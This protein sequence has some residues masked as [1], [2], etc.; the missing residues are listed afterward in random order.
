M[1]QLTFSFLT[2]IFGL[3]M[4]VTAD[5]CCDSETTTIQYGNKF[6][7]TFHL[8]NTGCNLLIELE[9]GASIKESF[10]TITCKD[11]DTVIINGRQLTK[12]FIVKDEDFAAVPL[13]TNVVYE[14]M[15]IVK[16][17][18]DDSSETIKS[19]N[20]VDTPEILFHP[21]L[22]DEADHI[23]FD[24]IEISYDSDNR[25]FRIKRNGEAKVK[26]LGEPRAEALKD[27][28]QDNLTWRMPSVS[29]VVLMTVIVIQLMVIIMTV[30]LLR[31]RTNV[32]KA[33]V[34]RESLL[35][36]ETSAS[37]ASHFSQ[38][39]TDSDG[40]CSA[41]SVELLEM[42]KN[43]CEKSDDSGAISISIGDDDET[44]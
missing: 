26:T 16:I 9:D 17:D 1:F 27:G 18:V 19:L 38:Y 32:A 24:D 6:G 14:H 4:S 23:T 33:V 20:L 34:R 21:S 8:D 11:Y 5:T 36:T 2:L 10:D 43:D 22:L 13:N 37:L 44:Q 40:D 12:P 25:Q 42:Q 3:V 31:S 35:W 30:M 39:S 29:E 41:D 28:K 15:P 7:W